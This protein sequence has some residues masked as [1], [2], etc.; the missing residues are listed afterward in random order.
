VREALTE[1]GITGMHNQFAAHD[2]SF[3]FQ[4]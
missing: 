2:L 4:L 1:I 3:S